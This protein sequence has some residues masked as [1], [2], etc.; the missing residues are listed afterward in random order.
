MKKIIL[1]LFILLNCFVFSQEC[2]EPSNVW[3]KLS[4]DEKTYGDLIT[5]DMSRGY[6]DTDGKYVYLFVI[7]KNTNEGL[8]IMFPIG[9]WE[10]EATSKFQ[11]ELEKEFKDL[12][13]YLKYN[14]GNGTE[15]KKQ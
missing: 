15:I 4:N 13:D 8:I 7:D 11:K 6:A 2:D 9:Y 1:T 14:Q 12:E 3:F 10:V 5:V